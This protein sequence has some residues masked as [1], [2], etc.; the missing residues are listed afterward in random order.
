MRPRKRTLPPRPRPASA[1]TCL[2][3]DLPLHGDARP[4][5]H[6]RSNARRAQHHRQIGAYAGRIPKGAKPADLP[7]V[8]ASKFELLINAV[9]ARMLGLNVPPSLFATADDVIEWCLA[10]G[11]SCRSHDLQI[12]RRRLAFV[13]HFFVLNILPLIEGA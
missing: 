6:H 11:N 1:K 10:D 12:L 9:T 3:Q 13:G 2:Y 4:R 5:F 7:M 8:Q